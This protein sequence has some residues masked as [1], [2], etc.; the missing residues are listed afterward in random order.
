LPVSRRDRLRRTGGSCPD[1]FA[2]REI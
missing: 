2:L 1:T